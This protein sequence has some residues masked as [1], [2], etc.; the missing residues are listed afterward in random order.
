LLLL[1][2]TGLLQQSTDSLTATHITRGGIVSAG[3]FTGWAAAAGLHAM[4]GN[5]GA[6][7]L[8]LTAVPVGALLVTQTS[9]A[10]VT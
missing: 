3:G 7:L 5:A 10:A 4:I 6:W 8:L 9:Y 2:A 1:A